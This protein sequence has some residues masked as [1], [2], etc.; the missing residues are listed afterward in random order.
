MNII[1]DSGSTKADWAFIEGSNIIIEYKT[2]G[3][4]P[5]FLSE[6]EITELIRTDLPDEALQK[7]VMR[8]FFY[9]AGCAGERI[10]AVKAAL[11]K[12]FESASTI[13]VESD[14]LGAARALCQRTSGIACILGTG[15]NSC[16]YDGKLIA[17]NVSPLGF[18]LGDEGSGAYLG[19]RMVGDLMKNQ[20]TPGLRE[21]FFA[22]QKLTIADIID[23]VY[24]SPL[25][26][27][28]LAS[29]QPF[30]EKHKNDESVK[31]L[32]IDSFRQ[33]FKRNV[34]QYDYHN[35]SANF[36]GSIAIAYRPFI[37]QAATECGV[38]IGKVEKSPMQ[39]LVYFHA[40][41]E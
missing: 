38:T 17:Q 12:C 6:E 26:N 3:I 40:K 34:C 32:L 28:F 23:R 5:V 22:E 41:S 30:L 25:P 33:F 21:Q 29:L 10:K 18:I 2:R 27:R 35:N 24:R 9:G 36:I 39:G 4:N 19:K 37:E 15:S 16:Y 14:M 13:E 7:P 11:K 31:R 20:L 1:V 8:I